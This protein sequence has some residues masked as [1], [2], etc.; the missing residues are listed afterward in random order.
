MVFHCAED[1][2]VTL[3][4]VFIFPRKAIH[5]CSF[6][7]VQE[8]HTIVLHKA[9]AGKLGGTIHFTMGTTAIYVPATRVV[10]PQV[11]PAKGPTA[12]STSL[13][14][15]ISAASTPTTSTTPSHTPMRPRCE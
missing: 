13:S 8:Q 4:D 14:A 6:N 15:V 5:M 9:G 3:A 1:V 2:P 11:P 10:E 12:P 7:T